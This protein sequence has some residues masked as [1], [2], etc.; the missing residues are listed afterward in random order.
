MLFGR[1]SPVTV[2]CADNDYPTLPRF[3]AGD[4]SGREEPFTLAV[5][6]DPVLSRA[7]ELGCLEGWG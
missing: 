6:Q 2:F 5:V 7:V 3:V 4:A 1:D